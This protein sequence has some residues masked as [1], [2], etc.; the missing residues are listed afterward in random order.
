MPDTQTTDA[1][2]S[3]MPQGMTAY[4]QKRWLAIQEWK[5]DASKPPKVHL[6]TAVRNKVDVVSDKLN[7]AWKAV[8]GNDKIEIWIAEA[9]NG[10]FHMTIDGLATTIH[11]D[12]IVRK[13]N[14]NTS[15]H[16]RSY[17]D[18]RMVDLEPLDRAR[19]DSKLVRSLA[20][21]GHGAASGFFAGGA[22]S[23][24]AATGGMGALPAAGAVAALAVADSVALI[25]GMVQGSAL[26][27]A[28]YG[29][30]PRKPS[31]HAM[32]MSMLG[33]GAAREAAKI[34]AMM[35]VRDLALALAA[36]RTIAQLSQ[37][38]LFNLMRRVYAL[39]LLKTTKKNI[40]KG[41]PLVGIGL[42]AGVNYGAARGV[43][44]AAQHLYPE[45][46][47]LVK[48]TDISDA[49][50][51]A[52]DV[53]AIFVDDVDES[54]LGILQRLEELPLLESEAEPDAAGAT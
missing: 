49:D 20:A 47:L 11:E 44:D 26:L 48:Y 18:F 34:V 7:D 45:R 16:V 9:I 41:L 43:L 28:H 27:G 15:D 25:G 53:E 4:E 24:G 3:Q 23:A 17:E 39:L 50:A 36:K 31:E 30:D 40:A 32:L 10:G 42:G 21:A 13:V 33:V 2:D 19:R 38:Q 5:L 51:W 54:D 8:P 35:Q 52:V 37:M 6:P 46:F 14:R 22:T 29:F 1:T 12:R